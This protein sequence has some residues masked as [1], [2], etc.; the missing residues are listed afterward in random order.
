MSKESPKQ[1]VDVFASGLID[2][3]EVL[4]MDVDVFEATKLCHLCFCTKAPCLMCVRRMEVF[5]RPLKKLVYAL[6]PV[7]QFKE[8]VA[9][10]L[11]AEL[12]ASD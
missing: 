6:M 10:A 4:S 5:K 12:L 8:E 7:E 2:L 1:V 3:K 9:G 11:V